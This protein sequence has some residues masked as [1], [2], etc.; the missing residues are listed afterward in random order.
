[1]QALRVALLVLAAAL[2]EAQAPIFGGQYTGDVR[3]LLGLVYGW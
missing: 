1:M 2:T 3:R